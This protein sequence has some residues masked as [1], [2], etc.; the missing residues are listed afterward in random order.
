MGL[1][2]DATDK[3]Y[4]ADK[5]SKVLNESYLG[6]WEQTQEWEIA[7]DNILKINMIGKELGANVGFVV[8]PVLLELNNNYPFKEIYEIVTKFGTDNHIPT[9]SLRPAFMGKNAP[10]LWVS[11]YDQ[12]PNEI[13]HEIAANSILPFLR[14]LSEE[15][16]AENN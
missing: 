16:L 9:H 14:R 12:H 8:F 3:T 4:L 7:K 6:N 13:A 10:D 1:F 11:A 5:Y 15:K 2:Q